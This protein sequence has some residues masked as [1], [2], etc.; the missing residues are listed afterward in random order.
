MRG[1]DIEMYISEDKNL[2]QRRSEF[3]I[4]K[5][6]IAIEN[7]APELKTKLHARKQDCTIKYDWIPLVKV[8]ANEGDAA[9][10]L[11]WN[12]SH[13]VA[14]GINEQL[15]SEIIENFTALTLRPHTQWSL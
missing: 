5:L 2:K 6:K 10:S 7:T 9:P 4:K 8:E 3:L 1:E 13:V 14:A 11:L 15:K 12:A